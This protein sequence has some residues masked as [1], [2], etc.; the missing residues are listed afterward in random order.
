MK[1]SVVRVIWK[2]DLHPVQSQISPHLLPLSTMQIC[3]SLNGEHCGQCTF[4]L[5]HKYTLQYLNFCSLLYVLLV[6]LSE[7]SHGGAV[8]CACCATISCDGEVR[9]HVKIVDDHS[10]FQMNKGMCIALGSLWLQTR[11]ISGNLEEQVRIAADAL[12]E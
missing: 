6:L 3:R 5:L 7:A 10:K 1:V 4:A 11:Y 2:G 8:I 12:P 9:V